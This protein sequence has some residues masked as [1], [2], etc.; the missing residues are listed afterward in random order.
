MNLATSINSDLTIYYEQLRQEILS[1][2]IDRVTT[3]SRGAGILLSRGMANWIEVINDIYSPIP[4]PVTKPIAAPTLNTP[5][6]ETREFTSILAEIA[7]RNIC[8][9]VSI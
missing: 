5:S 8:Q 2:S 3:K 4:K 6:S 7:L 1:S 9:E